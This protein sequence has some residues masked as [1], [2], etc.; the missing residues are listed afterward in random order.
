M[1]RHASTG[2]TADRPYATVVSRKKGMS[3]NICKC[4]SLV[5]KNLEHSV[6]TS[7]GP[8]KGTYKEEDGDTKLPG[9]PQGTAHITAIHTLISDTILEP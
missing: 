1:L 4:A 7:A 5:V 9:I 3:S 2:W 6:K 8:S